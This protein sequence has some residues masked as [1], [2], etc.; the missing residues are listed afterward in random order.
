MISRLDQI[1]EGERR[2]LPGVCISKLDQTK[3]RE[4][5]GHYQEF[6]T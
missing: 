4:R 2:E 6:A 5:E 3:E 1:I